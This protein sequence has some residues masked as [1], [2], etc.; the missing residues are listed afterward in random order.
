MKF[1]EICN[2]G[3]Y[4]KT[5][6]N[7]FRVVLE[8]IKKDCSDAWESFVSNGAVIYRG[9]SQT[10]DYIKVKPQ[11]GKRKSA[12]TLNYYTVA[13]SQLPSFKDYPPRDRSLICSTSTIKTREYGNTF[14][15]FP[16]NGTKIGIVNKKDIWYSTPYG[17]DTYLY[18]IAE[19]MIDYFSYHC[20]NTVSAQLNYEKKQKLGTT[21]KKFVETITPDRCGFT[22]ETTSDFYK[23]HNRKFESEIWFSNTAWM[24][25]EKWLKW[26]ISDIGI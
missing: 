26:W 10:S 21:Y 2:E 15:V 9:T 11:N 13:M 25:S 4:Q 3:I 7:P 14:V 20:C 22:L 17:N 23:N 1:S 19:Y 12:Y 5:K 8:E 18:E 6:R 24:I 16:L